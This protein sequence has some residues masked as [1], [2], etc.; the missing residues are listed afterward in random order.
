MYCKVLLL[1]EGN[2]HFTLIVKSFN[3]KGAKNSA[4][5]LSQGC[6]VIG[7]KE[8]SNPEQMTGIGNK[9]YLIA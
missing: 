7:V 1:T 3:E 4:K 6:S 5:R 2:N 8:C 9:A